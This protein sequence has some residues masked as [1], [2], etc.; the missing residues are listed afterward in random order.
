[1]QVVDSSNSFRNVI[2]TANTE[3]QNSQFHI[4]E[5]TYRYIQVLYYFFSFFYFVNNV[6]THEEIK[7]GGGERARPTWGGWYRVWRGIKA[8]GWRGR[9]SN[10]KGRG[11]LFS[12]YIFFFLSRGMRSH[13]LHHWTDFSSLSRSSFSLLLNWSW[14]S[15]RG[16]IGRRRNHG[17]R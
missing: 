1:M 11:V 2:Y 3:G 9:R 5:Y 6:D 17:W 12:L 7:L 16:G 15:S 4:P 8:R 10:S 14:S 13:S